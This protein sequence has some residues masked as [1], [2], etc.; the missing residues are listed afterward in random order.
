MVNY[1]KWLGMFMVT[2]LVV[3]MTA[4]SGNSG[5]A[6]NEDDKGS[7]GKKNKE[8]SFW[9]PF[10]GPDGPYMKEIVEAYNASQDEY[11]VKLQI[12]PPVRVL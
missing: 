8:I 6:D 10:S 12:V 4:C 7:S 2:L 11:N 9:A 5:V 3:I 1:K